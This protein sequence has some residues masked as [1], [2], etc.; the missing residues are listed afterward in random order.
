MRKMI[1]LASLSEILYLTLSFIIAQVYGQWSITGELIRTSLR[2]ISLF[3]FGYIYQNHFYSAN[4]SVKP[5]GA[6]TAPFIAAIQLL[7]LFAAS[8]TSAENETLLWQAVFVISGIAAGLREEL[9]YR[10]IL[11]KTLQTKYDYKIALFAATLIFTLS[12]IQYIAR[13]Q[14]GELMLIAF[15]GIIFGSIFIHTGSV[16]ISALVHSSYDAILSV[17]MLPFRLSYNA[18]M[19]I[20]FLIMLLF[21]LITS[22]KLL[23]SKQ[24][25]TSYGGDEDQFSMS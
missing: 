9:F 7:L 14:F 12:H 18:S 22:K 13:G 8:Y 24:A 23:S 17:N 20:L 6:F 5:K 10:G 4:Q 11:Q 25:D 21:L 3:F 1:A 2:I 15:A 16:A 19:P